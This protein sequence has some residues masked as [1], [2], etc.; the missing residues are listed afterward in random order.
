MAEER[1]TVTDS[2]LTEPRS[3]LYCEERKSSDEFNREH[4][5]QEA[6]GTY[7][8]NLVLRGCVC[9]ACNDYFSR[10][11]DGPLA[12]DSKEGLDRFEHRDVRPKAG[13]RIG[14][15]IALK[16]RGGR[17]DGAFLDWDVDPSGQDLSAKPAP[18]LGFA[19]S[20][21]GPFDWYRVED[22]PPA[23]VVRS[24]DLT[25]C[26]AGG[27]P[28]EDAAAILKSIGFDVPVGIPLDDPRDA[29]GMVATTVVGRIDDTLR[30]AIAKIAFN[31]FAYH[32][33]DLAF[34]DHFR[35]IRRYIRF[36]EAPTPYPVT[37]STDPIL[38]GLPKDTQV[39]GHIITTMWDHTAHQVVSQVSLYDWVQYRI[40]LSASP[41]LVAPIFVDS[42]HLFNPYAKQIAPLAR[43]PRRATPIP[44]TTREEL[45]ALK[46][47]NRGPPAPR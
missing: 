15:R 25:Y 21:A 35:S 6:F 11:L 42:G 40:T 23:D 26:I 13:R 22:I 4:V 5:L 12:R 36:G 30:R 8:D 7:E 9:T 43:D 17:L 38:G 46:V 2:D 14:T 18:Q 28:L 27:L 45:S 34:L 24:R 19:T 29:D 33:R 41:F 31:Y 39:V 47:K 20:E 1:R 37:V 44:L 16:Q 3:C 32:H 10:A